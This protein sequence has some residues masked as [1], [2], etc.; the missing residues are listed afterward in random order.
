MRYYANLDDTGKVV[1]TFE[2]ETEVPETDF[3]KE[4]DPDAFHG[5][6]YDEN[7]MLTTTPAFRKNYAGIGFYYHSDI[8]AFVPPS[9]FASWVIDADQGLYVS[10]VPEPP[11]DPYSP[12]T[13]YWDEQTQQ[14]VKCD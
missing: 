3:V 13:Y 14:W 2:S 4:Y 12:D 5:V 1:S 7:H 11:F 10:P 9:P 8:D 6:Q